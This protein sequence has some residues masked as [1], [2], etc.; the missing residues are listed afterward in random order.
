[1][2]QA[3]RNAMDMIGCDMV[4]ASRMASGNPARFLRLDHETGAIA[5]GLRADLVH[6]GEDRLVRSTWIAGSRE[7]HPE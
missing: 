2:A 4:T 7:D 3:L 6:L 5:P 1:M